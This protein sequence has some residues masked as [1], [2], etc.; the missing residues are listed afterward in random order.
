MAILMLA[1]NALHGQ[2]V[3]LAE[4][5][6]K[7]SGNDVEMLFNVS[8]GRASGLKGLEST[9]AIQDE[10]DGDGEPGQEFL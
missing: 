9:V 7:A 1:N 5:G 2:D 10:M 4:M 6:K 8:G 3:E